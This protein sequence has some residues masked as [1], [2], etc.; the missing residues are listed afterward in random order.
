MGDLCNTGRNGQPATRITTQI[1]AAVNLSD[2][3]SSQATERRV[4]ACLLD[5]GNDALL[6]VSESGLTP[7]MFY[8]P[9]CRRTYETACGLHA[10]GLPFGIAEVL[11]RQRPRPEEASVL[12]EITGKNTG[13]MMILSRLCVEIRSLAVRRKTIE[14]SSQLSDAARGHPDEVFG[15][16]GE[17]LGTQA[18]TG[19]ARSMAKVCTDARTRA[20]DAIA[21]KVNPAGSLSWGWAQLDARFQPMQS[22]ELVVVAARPSVGKSSFARGIASAAAI[23]GRA[24]LFESL[25]VS[26]DRVIDGMAT[27]SSGL[28][29][30]EL[31]AAP[32]DLQARYLAAIDRLGKSQ[33]LVF[34]DRSLAGIIARTKA[35][36]AQT[37]LAALVVDYLGLITD[38]QPG[39]GE[40]KSQ[41]VGRVTN[42]LKA[43]AMELK[44]VVICLA[45]LNRQ[46][47][48]DG[49]REPRLSDLRDS[50]DI[51]QD[52]DRVIF[53]HR[54][55]K[56]PFT[57]TEQSAHAESDDLPKYGCHLIQ[58]KGRDVG[59]GYG[60]VWFN[61][62]LARFEMP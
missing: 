61:R 18:E 62:K 56:C 40:T 27:G 41:A 23:A 21:G 3:P 26:A 52:A 57:G 13:D 42:A 5:N 22:G 19:K 39:K 6:A 43:L 34:E 8:D 16:I 55:D 38:C 31:A 49:N 45:Q 53:I 48:N 29:S 33:L 7:A 50:G 46:L 44:I 30:R 4:I 15:I 54:P 60:Q 24:I 51:E 1:Q 17:L 11:E 20:L 35:S 9:L 32:K 2:L 37:P 10:T 25:E 58:E 28:N 47:A 12:L 14:L 59:T 36:H